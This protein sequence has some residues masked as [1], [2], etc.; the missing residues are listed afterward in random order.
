M[1]AVSDLQAP[2]YGPPAM[3]RTPWGDATQLRDKKLPT[4]AG[5]AAR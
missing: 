4:G 2:G 5:N 3:A 1:V